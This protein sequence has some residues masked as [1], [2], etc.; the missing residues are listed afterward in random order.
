MISFRFTTPIY[1]SMPLIVPTVKTPDTVTVTKSIRTRTLFRLLTTTQVT[2]HM[3]NDPRWSSTT[4]DTLGFNIRSFYTLFRLPNQMD[5]TM[6]ELWTMMSLCRVSSF[7]YIKVSGTSFILSVSRRLSFIWSVSVLVHTIWTSGTRGSSVI[8]FVSSL[9]T[10]NLRWTYTT[11]FQIL[12]YEKPLFPFRKLCYP[13]T[14]V[15]TLGTLCILSC[16]RGGS[17]TYSQGTVPSFTLTL[18]SWFE[19]K[20]WPPPFSGVSILQ[21]QKRL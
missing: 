9:L 4:T 5:K 15:L 20:F 2:I 8:S 17:G 18:T 19:R 13:G 6:T 7:T 10:P 21:E 3:T 11:T 16:L 14:V 12:T 1:T